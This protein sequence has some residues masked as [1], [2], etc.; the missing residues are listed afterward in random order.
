MITK[1]KIMKESTFIELTIEATSIANVWL[2]KNVS[3]K[4]KKF[5]RNGLLRK[6]TYWL[7]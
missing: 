7:I 3:Q 4:M 1:A 5:K 2:A 6:Y